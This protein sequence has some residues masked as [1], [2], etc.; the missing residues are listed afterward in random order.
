MHVLLLGVLRDGVEPAVQVVLVLIQLNAGLHLSCWET[1]GITDLRMPLLDLGLEKINAVVRDV[2][3]IN[4]CSQNCC[5]L[6]ADGTGLTYS[7][8]TEGPSLSRQPIYS[9]ESLPWQQARQFNERHTSK[10]RD[11][12]KTSEPSRLGGKKFLVKTR[13]DLRIFGGGRTIQ[14]ETFSATQHGNRFQSGS[15]AEKRDQWPGETSCCFR[16][17]DRARGGSA[18]TV[19]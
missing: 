5:H 7:T 1:L 8:N 2:R 15:G 17:V 4:G 12:K 3:R 6:G 10:P 14:L 19:G 18:W 9:K 16:V 11:P 13:V